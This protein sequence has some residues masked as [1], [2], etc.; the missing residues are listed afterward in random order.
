MLNLWVRKLFTYFAINIYAPNK[1][2]WLLDL[3]AKFIC[4]FNCLPD[5]IYLLISLSIL[6]CTLLLCK[7]QHPRLLMYKTVVFFQLSSKARFSL[8]IITYVGCTI[9]VFCLVISWI[10]FAV[11]KWVILTLEV[12]EHVIIISR[13]YDQRMC[14]YFC[15]HICVFL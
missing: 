4:V 12:N 3:N 7:H 13:E 2:W 6:P 14:F 5:F 11:F 1:V 9:S 10:T 8:E 15:V